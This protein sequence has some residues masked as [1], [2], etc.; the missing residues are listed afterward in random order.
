HLT[1]SLMSLNAYFCALA[2]LLVFLAGCATYPG[3]VPASESGGQS[4][5]S[6]G[7]SLRQLTP[8]LENQ[9]LATNPEHVTADDVRDVLSRAPAPR[10]IGIH[11]GIYPVHLAMKSFALFLVGMGYPEECVRRPCDGHYSFS[12]CESSEKIAGA[13]AW[14]YEKDGLRP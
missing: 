10:I 5:M 1:K 6:A 12:C 9:L 13:I 7:S 11:G 2:G 4:P 3:Y 8:E 14:Y